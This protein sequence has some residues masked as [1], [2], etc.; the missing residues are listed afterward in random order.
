MRSFIGQLRLLEGGTSAS[1]V[2]YTA[3]II[4]PAT[5]PHRLPTSA[6][7]PALESAPSKSPREKVLFA[8]VSALNYQYVNPFLAIFAQTAGVT[9]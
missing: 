5:L 9:D 6:T 8:I 4:P 2:L 1:S 7:A 3:S